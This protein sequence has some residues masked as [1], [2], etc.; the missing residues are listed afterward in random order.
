V[1]VLSGGRR[2]DRGDD[3]GAPRAWADRRHH[4]VRQ[5]AWPAL[6]LRPSSQHRSNIRPRDKMLTADPLMD[7][8]HRPVRLG[9][10]RCRVE[11]R[12]DGSILMQLE[13]ALQPYPRRYTDRLVEWARSAPD[14]VFLARRPPGG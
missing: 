13:E 2:S 7:V 14:R 12:A 8:P 5:G 9:S 1:L 6:T 10:T 3:R 11:H 4:S